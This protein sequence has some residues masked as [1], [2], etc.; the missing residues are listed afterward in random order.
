MR[1]RPALHYAPVREGVY[2]GM[3]HA[4]FVVRGPE[5]L[6]RIVDVC[7]PLLEDGATEDELVAALGDERARP[8]VSRLVAA[9]SGHGLLLDLDRLTV[10]EPGP[11][12]RERYREALTD[13]ETRHADPYAAFARVRA[14]TVLVCGPAE[15]VLPAAR[16]L[17]RAGAGRLVLAVPDPAAVAATATRLGAACHALTAEGIDADG[18]DVRADAA[19]LCAEAAD[20]D[21]L[22]EQ[23][24]KLLPEGCPVVPVLLDERFHLT[25]LVPD[26]SWQPLRSR[27]ALWAEADGPQEALTRPAA[28]ALAGALAGQ[29]VFRALTG[30]AAAEAYAVYGAALAADRI[31][32]TPEGGR[33][34]TADLDEAVEVVQRLAKRWTGALNLVTAADLPQLP[35]ALV[36][37]EHRAEFQGRFQAE[38]AGSVVGWGSDQRSATVSAALAALRGQCDPQAGTAAAALTEERWLLDGALRLLTDRALPAGDQPS[39]DDLD[40]AARVLWRTLEDYELLRINVE[41]MRLPGLEWPLGLVRDTGSGELLGSAWGPDASRAITAA[42]SCALARVQTRRVRG[43]DLAGSLPDTTTLVL[44]DADTVAGL[45]EQLARLVQ[46]DGERRADVLLGE[47]PVWYGPVSARSMT[48]EAADG[49]HA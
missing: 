12:E 14:A 18:I 42:L 1:L 47:L 20:F 22:L 38:Q 49:R 39:F 23:Q 10:P 35:L 27:V 4:S 21:R 43:A 6:F 28:D 19:V 29:L 33:P 36:E 44:A 8:I 16:G 32:L 41:L 25:G 5:A 46:V 17:A 2:F 7:V 37:V 9:L 40:K 30:T 48:E 31:E 13:L 26:G 45:G 34:E 11:E 24:S 3:E 15:A